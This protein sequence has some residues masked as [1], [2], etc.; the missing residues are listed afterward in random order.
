[1]LRLLA[2]IALIS[3]PVAA[4]AAEVLRFKEESIRAKVQKPEVGYIFSRPDLTP[5][6]DLELRESFLPRIEQSVQGKPF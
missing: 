1:M 4:Q 2:C 3:L 5:R 6:Y